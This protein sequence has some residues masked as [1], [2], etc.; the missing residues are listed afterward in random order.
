MKNFLILI[1]GPKGSGKST[2][3]V[4]L[5]T[6]LSNTEFIGLDQMRKSIPES[7]PTDEFN[8]KASDLLLSKMAELMSGRINI[9]VDGI[10]NARIAEL[11]SLVQNSGYKLLKY[12]LTAP[13]NV[14][15]D[16][17]KERDR[18]KGKMTDEDRFHYTYKMQ[19]ASDL[20][21]YK[22]F[23]TST[24]DTQAIV[25]VILKELQNEKGN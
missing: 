6:K 20:S 3:V 18:A 10:S 4:L 22:V 12:A 1:K 15:L 21:S 16:R 8:A 23:D 5:K 13:I 2:T 11:E 14:L 24:T 7:K 17:V 19:Q 25:S 9:V